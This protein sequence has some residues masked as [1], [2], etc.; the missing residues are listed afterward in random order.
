MKLFKVQDFRLLVAP[1][2]VRERVMLL[3]PTEIRREALEQLHLNMHLSDTPSTRATMASTAHLDSIP[4]SLMVSTIAP[5]NRQSKAS[6]IDPPTAWD[7]AE[8]KRRRGPTRKDNGQQTTEDSQT[9]HAR[10]LHQTDQHLRQQQNGP[11]DQSQYVHGTH[12][13][14][15]E[16]AA[17]PIGS[18]TKNVARESLQE[19]SEVSDCQTDSLLMVNTQY[20]IK[21]VTKAEEQPHQ[22]DQPRSAHSQQVISPPTERVRHQPPTS[23]TMMARF[24]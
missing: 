2:V 24:W 7:K 5:V 6:A 14:A 4:P 22:I 8:Y 15:I 10:Q 11:P 20:F 17:G 9:Q 23:G 1:S 21:G 18:D 12:G 19:C 13:T 3:L 16:I